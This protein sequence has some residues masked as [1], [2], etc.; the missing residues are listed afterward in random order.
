MEDNNL[1][2]LVQKAGALLPANWI[3]LDDV[4]TPEEL[5][6]LADMVEKNYKE[7]THG[8]SE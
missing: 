2:E 7:I 8:V 4:Y 3:K 5:R 1:E 6:T